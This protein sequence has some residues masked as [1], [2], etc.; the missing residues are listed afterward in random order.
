MIIED[1]KV[2]KLNEKTGVPIGVLKEKQKHK[3]VDE[4][5]ELIETIELNNVRKKNETLE[6]KKERKQEVKKMRKE[7]RKEK[8]DNKRLFE[9]EGRKQEII[10]LNKA[11]SN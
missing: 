11:K 7:R 6:E 4:I 10:N 2:I 1:K 5:K 8:K 3:D 9:N